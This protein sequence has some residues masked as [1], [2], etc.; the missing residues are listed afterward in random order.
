MTSTSKSLGSCLIAVF[1]AS[2]GGGGGGSSGGA[3][4]I[5]NASPGG[6]WTFV[7]PITRAP[8][9]A[10]IAED[11]RFQVYR[12]DGSDTQYWGTVSTI[13][14]SISGSNIQV[15]S[16]S[17]YFG[18]A[19]LTN[20]TISERQSWTATFNFTPAAGCPASVCGV[21][22]SQVGTLNFSSVYNQGGA[23]TRIAG[24]WRDTFTGTI[25]NVNSSGVFFTQDPVTRCVTNGQISTI[26]TSYNAYAAQ[27]TF[28]MCS[29]RYAYQNGTTATGLAFV[30][31]GVTPNRAYFAGQYRSSSGATY[32]TT[33]GVGIKQ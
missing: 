6:F 20:G 31:T 5:R 10:L 14:S 13:G 24:N 18:S 32:Y 29:A 19:T 8:S 17:T 27:Y 4:P 26:N 15:A 22:S 11:G 2:C 12:D 1:L 7:D 9:Y 28:S 23:L 21:A 3:T 30:D 25:Y 16:G 33:W